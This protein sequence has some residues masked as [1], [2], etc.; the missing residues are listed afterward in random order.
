MAFRPT[1]AALVLP[2]LWF[3]CQGEGLPP[4]DEPSPP[5]AANAVAPA[6]APP[7]GPNQVTPGAAP[8]RYDFSGGSFVTYNR[9]L[10]GEVIEAASGHVPRRPV[11][12]WAGN[13]PAGADDP[14][15]AQR[16]EP[17]PLKVASSQQPRGS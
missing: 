14:T 15:G 7:P 9:S 5:E 3:G 2:M 4:G 8:T 13:E 16:L 1:S 17:P 12:V 11:L 10:P 6:L